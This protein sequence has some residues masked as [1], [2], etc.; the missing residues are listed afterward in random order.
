MKSVCIIS[1]D[2]I[3]SRM[4]ELELRA[5]PLKINLVYEKLNPA[6]LS[7]AV[8]SSDIVIYDAQYSNGDLSFV[9]NSSVNFVIFGDT[10][11]KDM[12][13]NVKCF[14]E[15]PFLVSEFVDKFA[16]I[17]SYENE[18]KGSLTY[19]NNNYTIELEPFSKQATVNGELIKFSKREYS[20]LSLLYKNRGKVVTRREV[21]DTVWGND[22][23]EKN[24]VDNVYVNYLRN[25]IDKKLGINLIYT[26]RGKGYMMK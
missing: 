20:L 1:L 11:A 26:I 21:L 13:E 5:F 23:E 24:N 16:E 10:S 3:F 6:A 14:F 8:A 7:L 15:R 18:R 4:L 12:P 2:R 22:Y 19:Q 17:L 25:K 9:K